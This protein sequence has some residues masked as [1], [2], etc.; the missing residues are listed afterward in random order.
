M[1]YIELIELILEIQLPYALWKI[2]GIT[3]DVLLSDG[4]N[5][6]ASTFIYL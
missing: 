2:I 1:N 3:C 4:E 5:P 6:V